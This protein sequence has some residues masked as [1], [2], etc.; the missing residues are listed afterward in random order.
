FAPTTSGIPDRILILGGHIVFVETKAPGQSVRRLQQVRHTA[1][2]RRGMD[3]RVVDTIDDADA[4]IAEIAAREPISSVA[5][6]PSTEEP[7]RRPSCPSVPCS[8]P[9]SPRPQTPCPS[10][11]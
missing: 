7:C 10:S 9:R 11:C 1:L 2:R 4:L 8:R 5:P 3:V 6:T